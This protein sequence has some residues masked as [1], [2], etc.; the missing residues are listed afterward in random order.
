M[1]MADI[2]NI[3]P[4]SPVLSVIIGLVVAVF[5]LYLARGPAHKAFYSLSRIFHNGFRLMAR[6][7][8]IAEKKVVERNKEVLPSTGAKAVERLIER[9][10]HRV[11]AVVRRDMSGYP[12]LQGGCPQCHQT[13]G[14]QY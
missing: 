13:K 2:L 6:S 9:Q 3:W 4:N 14:R 12:A 8:L 11:D 7:A 1:S 10:F 5:L